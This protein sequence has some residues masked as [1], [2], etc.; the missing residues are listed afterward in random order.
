MKR[1]VFGGYSVIDV[2]ILKI[3]IIHSTDKQDSIKIMTAL[4]TKIAEFA[5]ISNITRTTCN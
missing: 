2:M 3:A 5:S 1:T 4:G